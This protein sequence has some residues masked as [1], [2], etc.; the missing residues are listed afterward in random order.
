MS[1]LLTTATLVAAARALA[2]DGRP[3]RATDAVVPDATFH[4]PEITPGPNVKDLFRRADGDSTVL[5]GPD[6]TCGYV[7]GRAGAPITCNTAYTCALVIESTYGRAGCYSGEDFGIRAT[8]YD[9]NQVYQSSYCDDGCLQDTYTLKCT[10][11]TAS[12]CN[13]ITFFS[14]V[15]DFFCASLNIS[16]PQQLYTTYNGEDDGRTWQ[17]VV[18]TPTSSGTDAGSATD[19]GSVFFTF[20]S[21][22]DTDFASGTSTSSTGSS[23]GS[24]GGSSGSSGSSSDSG[25]SPTTKKSSTPIGP[26]V[27]G[28]V[29]GVAAL[30][31][32]G[33]AIF[34][35]VRHNNNKKKV[36]SPEQ[37]PM[38]QQPQQPPAPGAGAGYPPQQGGYTNGAAYGQP[39]YAQQTPPPPQGYYPPGTEQKPAGFVGLTPVAGVPDRH[40][41]TSPVSQFSDPRHSTQPHSPTST[42]NSNWGAQQP[43]MPASPNVPPTVHEAG[44]N[45]VGDRDYNSNHHGQFH[46]MA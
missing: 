3:A 5:I 12:Y 26:I 27:G 22:T 38:Q 18:L 41:S 6:N 39:P 31:L 21:S 45:A 42:L 36:T 15:I 40:D 24:S 10:E 7:S 44:G 43:P 30:A 14:G 20:G 4:L 32:L 16:T 2:F 25:N 9:Y 34:F 29:G 28:V 1:R 23:T 17:E 37:P 33:L 13:T 8:C 35:L 46:E 19:D 11:T